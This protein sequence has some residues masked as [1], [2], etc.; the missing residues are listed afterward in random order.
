M[1]HEVPIRLT[2]DAV[3][4]AW[5]RF[6]ARAVGRKMAAGLAVAVSATIA[7]FWAGLRGWP[8][9]AFAACQILAVVYFPAVFYHQRRRALSFFRKM[10]AVSVTLFF[11]DDGF[12]TRSDF[13]SSTSPWRKIERVW[14][15]PEVWLVFH[16]RDR[17]SI[18]P[19]KDLPSTAAEYILRKVSTYAG[20]IR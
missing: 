18:I 13:G 10:P 15:F 12:E 8:L 11:S 16:T 3:R 17:F 20:E 1:Q 5:G 4:A 6:W 9:E 19:T 2:E 7:L 14:R